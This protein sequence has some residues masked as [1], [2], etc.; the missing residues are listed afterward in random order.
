MYR[1][2]RDQSCALGLKCGKALLT[3][4]PDTGPHIEMQPVLDNLATR[5]KSRRGPTAEGSVHA[6]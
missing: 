1:A 2:E 4:E 6:K 5:W 3:H